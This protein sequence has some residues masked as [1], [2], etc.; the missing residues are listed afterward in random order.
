MYFEL[1]DLF[2][3]TLLCLACL[4]WWH[5]Q[6]A[7]EVALRAAVK[8]C[9]EM[10]LQLLDHSIYLRGFWFKRDHNGKL[11]IWRSYLFDFTATGDDRAKGRVAML[12]FKVTGVTLETHRI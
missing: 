11:R 8:E 5:G 10:D 9:K 7:K 2:W 1:S 12:G 4:H 3:L 6:K